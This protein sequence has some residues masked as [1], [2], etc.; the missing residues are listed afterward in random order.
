VRLRSVHGCEDN[1]TPGTAQSARQRAFFSAS[2]CQIASRG[3]AA[4]RLGCTAKQAERSVIWGGVLRGARVE[5][6]RGGV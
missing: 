4:T 2:D 3:G 1:M 6:G 5:A